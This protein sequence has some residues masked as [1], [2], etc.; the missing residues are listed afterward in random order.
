M[1]QALLAFILGIFA[2]EILVQVSTRIM[3]MN[4]H[5]SFAHKSQ[6]LRTTLMSFYN[7]FDELWYIAIAMK[8][9]TTAPQNCIVELK[10]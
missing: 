2:R 3:D 9:K 7:Q 4:I 5:N 8:K 10:K 1:P 6:K